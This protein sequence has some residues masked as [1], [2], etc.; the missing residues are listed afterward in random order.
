M[1]ADSIARPS[2]P[3]YALKKNGDGDYLS[4]EVRGHLSPA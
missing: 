4:G 2:R 3:F 1:P